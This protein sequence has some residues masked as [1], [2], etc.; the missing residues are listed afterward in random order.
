MNTS[1]EYKISRIFEEKSKWGMVRD[2]ATVH[3]LSELD[4]VIETTNW[5]HSLFKDNK[6]EISHFDRCRLIALDIDGDP[7]KG[8]NLTF[9][10]LKEHFL[11][12]RHIIKPTKSHG[13]IKDGE[14]LNRFR[15]ILVLDKEV[16]SKEV[17]ESTWATLYSKFPFIDRQAK[18]PSRFWFPC[19]STPALS[20]SEEGKFIKVTE[21]KPKKEVRPAPT[22]SKGQNLTDYFPRLREST[23]VFLCEGA[24]D[25]EFNE[26]L[27]LAALDCYSNN[28]PKDLFIEQGCRNIRDKEFDSTDL[29]TINS[30]YEK[31]REKREN[32]D[33]SFKELIWQSYLIS[34]LRDASRAY[35][36]NDSDDYFLQV[37][38]ASIRN[39]LGSESYNKEYS[40][41]MGISAIV[42]YQPRREG[43]RIFQKEKIRHFNV[44]KKPNWMEVISKNPQAILPDLYNEFFRHLTDHDHDSFEYLLDWLALSLQDRNRTILVAIGEQGIGKGV[45]GSIM[46]KLHGE[47][48]FSKTN[49]AIFKERFNG[50]LLHKTLV[51]VDEI[52]IGNNEVAYNRLKD[53]V[54][55]TI[56]IEEKCKNQISIDN[57]ASFYICSNN[58]DAIPLE[59]G[60]RRF[61]LIWLTEEKLFKSQIAK[62]HGGTDKLVSALYE[63]T[64]IKLFGEYLLSRAVDREAMLEPFA[65]K[66]TLQLK[67]ACLKE[68]EEWFV[69]SWCSQ[70]FDSNNENKLFNIVED[71]KPAIHKQFPEL[72][73]PP[74]QNKL[75]ELAA[76]Y[77]KAFRVRKISKINHS[78]AVQILP[79]IRELVK[80]YEDNFNSEEQNGD[81]PY[82]SQSN[83]ELI[84]KFGNMDLSSE[85]N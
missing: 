38:K 59:E 33:K 74:G 5:S 47:K 84:E 13:E 4:K 22:T 2:T 29:A 78:R 39:E 76:K 52:K 79:T 75:Q 45:L 67:A 70:S 51:H 57:H 27:Y 3:S 1:Q 26:K 82:G 63:E 24:K 60:Q 36:Y 34:D 44:Y 73:S 61:S 85:L 17:Y 40:P 77:P 48:N 49:D 31:G 55:D 32:K 37:D 65:S 19:A 41:E 6:R 81:L 11:E 18:D 42:D 83:A 62:D 28:V 56:Q 25:G 71:I 21:E 7:K 16:E 54:N 46:E 14:T 15:V 58:H 12:Y 50:P 66:K 80:E 53:I 68:W 8:Q 10:E 69:F 9:K 23:K 72:S 20:I 64:N 30:A 35:L 43:H